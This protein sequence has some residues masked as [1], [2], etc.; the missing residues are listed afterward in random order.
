MTQPKPKDMNL[1]NKVKRQLYKRIP[2]HS[3]YRSGILV[4]NYK[5]AYFKKYKKH[6]AYTGKK[7]KKRGLKRWFLEDWKNQRGEIGFK[8]KHDIY[9]PTNRITK[10]TPLTHDE[11]TKK[12]LKKARQ[13]KYRKGRVYR[14]RNN[15]SKRKKNNSIKKKKRKSKRKS[16][17]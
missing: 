11:L 7:T 6:N 1:Y 9:R 10:N 15:K 16:N 13:T 12:E 2:Q 8:Y 14:F 5:K 4:K 3:A 17:N